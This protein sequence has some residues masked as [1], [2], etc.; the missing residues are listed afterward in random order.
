MRIVKELAELAG[1]HA[2]DG[3]LRYIGKRQELDISGGYEEQSYYDTHVIPLFNIVFSTSIH[4]KFFP[5]RK[6][7][8]FVCR[9]RTILQEFRKL[10]FPS[11]NKSKIVR[12]PKVILTSTDPAIWCRFLRG[13]FD[14]DGCLTF[15]K[16]V[17]AKRGFP[18]ANHHYPRIMFTTTSPGL[19]RDVLDLLGRIGINARCYAHTPRKKTESLK[20][21][22]QVVGITNLSIWMKR[23]GIANPSKYSRYRIWMLQGFCPPNTTFVQRQQLLS[24]LSK[25]V[26]AP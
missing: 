20:S 8:G 1:I 5:S 11:G 3:Y 22:I 14:T 25:N 19:A 18:I 24:V 23:I 15:D 17:C 6:T 10:G 4:G 9:N 16:R 2:G 12:C 21:K 26:M 7:Y 13:Y